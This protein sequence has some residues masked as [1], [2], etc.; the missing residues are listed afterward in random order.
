MDCLIIVDTFRDV[1]ADQVEG[2]AAGGYPVY[3][4]TVRTKKAGRTVRYEL[5]EQT[6]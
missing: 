5:S 3:R 2:V 6:S 1:V 4:A